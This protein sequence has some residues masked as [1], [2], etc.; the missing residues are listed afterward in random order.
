MISIK[1]NT[2]PIFSIIDNTRY[3]MIN[4]LDKKQAKFVMSNA[5]VD[6]VTEK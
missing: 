2:I 4:N 5:K 1:G 6:L 3:S